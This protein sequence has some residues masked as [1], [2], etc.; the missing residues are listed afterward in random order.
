VSIDLEDPGDIFKV[1]ASRGI[2]D[3]P[4]LFVDE[5][6]LVYLSDSAVDS[7]LRAISGRPQCEFVGYA[8][9]RADDDFGKLIFPVFQSLGAPLKGG[10]RYDTPDEAIEKFSQAGFTFARAVSSEQAILRFLS[11]E[12]KIRIAGLECFDEN[13]VEILSHYLTIVAG[14][15]RFVSTFIQPVDTNPDGFLIKCHG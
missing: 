5:F 12:D 1:L 6:S 10:K 2:E 8:M 9:V 15:S 13:H 7:L 3:L 4:T 11:R 14:S